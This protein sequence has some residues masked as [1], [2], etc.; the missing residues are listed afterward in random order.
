MKR[1]GCFLTCGYTETG[2]MQNFLSK[3]NNN[4]EY[5]QLLPNKPIKKKGHH[6]IKN[7][8]N[9]ATGEALIKEICKLLHDYPYIIDN[10]DALLIEDDLDGRY[11]NLSNLQI[12]QYEE[13]VRAKI[14]K[15]ISKN[16]KKDIPILFMYAS[17]EIESWFIA[18]WI[19][20]FG[21]IFLCDEN[22]NVR[23]IPK[24]RCHDF[25]F[26]M[27]K[28]II[29]EILSSRLEDIERFNSGKLSNHLNN[30]FLGDLQQYINT[31]SKST[32]LKEY[33]PNKSFSY[34]KAIEGRL[35]LNNIEPE[36]LLEYCTHYFKNNYIKLKN[37]NL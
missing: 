1:I 16:E 15:E 36:N 14:R 23:G 2:V 3:I 5:K 27:H 34:S 6:L 22:I 4:Y 32:K 9:G 11:L 30:M 21:W 25:T 13:D 37:L 24:P 10:C 26:N 17:P 20:G 12:I 19:N 7:S 8:I 33:L 35:M 31:K 29:N 18:D 28:Y